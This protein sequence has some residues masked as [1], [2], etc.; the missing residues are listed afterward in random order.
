MPQQL[1]PQKTAG[2]PAFLPRGGSKHSGHSPSEDVSGSIV[3]N[4]SELPTS[5][6]NSAFGVP[7]QR[8]PAV[9]A[10][11]DSALSAAAKQDASGKL[12]CALLTTSRSVELTSWRSLIGFPG[13]RRSVAA[14]VWSRAT[15]AY[16]SA[17][18]VASTILPYFWDTNP[19]EASQDL[20]AYCTRR[21]LPADSLAAC[22]RDEPS[23]SGA[24]DQAAS[25]SPETVLAHVSPMT[26]IK[27]PHCSG[28]FRW[29]DAEHVREADRVDVS[30]KRSSPQPTQEGSAATCNTEAAAD[31]VLQPAGKPLPLQKS[32]MWNRRR[33]PV[34]ES[35][36]VTSNNNGEAAGCSSEVQSQVFVET[37]QPRWIRIL[38][39][40]LKCIH[41][42]NDRHVLE[43][44]Q[45]SQQQRHVGRRRRLR[46]RHRRRFSKETSRAK[47]RQGT[48]E[49]PAPAHSEAEN[50]D[51]RAGLD[52]SSVEAHYESSNGLV[53]MRQ[54]SESA[55]HISSVAPGS[56]DVGPETA[57]IHAVKAS[58]SCGSLVGGISRRPAGS[59]DSTD[60][61]KGMGSQP[62]AGAMA[63]EP[64]PTQMPACIRDI[65]DVEAD[66]WPLVSLTA[67]DMRDIRD[68]F[69]KLEEQRLRFNSLYLQ[70]PPPL[71]NGSTWNKRLEMQRLSNQLVNASIP[72]MLVL[73]CGMPC[74][75]C[76]DGL[77]VWK[78]ESAV[79]SFACRARFLLPVEP[80]LY[81]MFASNSE[82]RCQWDKNVTE[83][84]VVEQLEAGRDVCYVAFRRIA[85]VYPRDL[86]TLRVKCRLPMRPK[87]ADVTADLVDGYGVGRSCAEVRSGSQSEADMAA[88]SSMS[89]SIVHPDAPELPGRV[90]MDVRFNA[91]L[92]KPVITP[93]GL[94]S[95]VTL[96]NESDPG[97]WIPAAIT[98]NMCAKLLPSTL[99]KFSAEIMKHY[100][101][102]W[103]GSAV[104]FAAR[105]LK[106]NNLVLS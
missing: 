91:Y 75:H 65:Q 17:I 70:K 25:L 94:W 3:I 52:R 89:C 43:S 47:E 28:T 63:A 21:Q 99:E 56:D 83:Q 50:N 44:R 67:M 13:I 106:M 103:T 78:G 73:D 100:N 59:L 53:S 84:H 27:C 57:G 7:T 46:L 102:A 29:Q 77:Q 18:S 16:Y 8:N 86:V 62:C 2:P 68:A 104:G 101:I 23:N 55:V 5:S 20:P 95:E 97:G 9:P 93:F 96:V 80:R 51:S 98:R 74:V 61:A 32:A 79:G 30:F 34:V 6:K 19:V 60:Q 37:R 31:V 36:I 39:K 72:L 38:V 69:E 4:I 10:S 105:Q 40:R 15:Y 58:S 24:E 22:T 66:L 48:L 14:A 85:T 1:L 11:Q 87:F 26:C 12:N 45:N 71:V 33:R 88:Y 42:S 41:V 54:V 92:A 90:R 64:L 76:D 81:A 82:L 49:D 35:P